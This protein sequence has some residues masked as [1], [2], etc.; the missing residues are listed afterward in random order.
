MDVSYELEVFFLLCGWLP[1]DQT[2]WPNLFIS[3]TSGTNF[4]SCLHYLERGMLFRPLSGIFGLLHEDALRP[5]PP[6]GQVMFWKLLDMYCYWT[7]GSA[8]TASQN[9]SI[10]SLFNR[11]RNRAFGWTMVFLMACRCKHLF[12]FYFLKMLSL[13]GKTLQIHM[14]NIYSVF[15]VRVRSPIIL[16]DFFLS[17]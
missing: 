5:G 15:T 8:M 3:Y 1:D 6:D 9:I 2:D 10:I 7:V 16:V 12:F 11:I 17:G 13:H 4:S 14:L